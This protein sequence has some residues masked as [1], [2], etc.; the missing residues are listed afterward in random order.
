[1]P[2]LTTG[3]RWASVAVAAVLALSGCN[4]TG[5]A[6]PPLTDAT[7]TTTIE[8]SS[9]TSAPGTAPL[10]AP[11]AGEP[12]PE[13]A[14]PAFGA[15]ALDSGELQWTTCSEDEMY[16]TMIGATAEVVLG[17]EGS[18]TGTFMVA[19]DASDG[20]ELWRRSAFAGG[21]GVVAPGPVGGQ[22]ITVVQTDTELPPFTVA[23]DI[24]SGEERRRLEPGVGMVGQ[25]DEVVVVSAAFGQ[26][27]APPGTEGGLRGIDRATGAELW[28]NDV[29]FSDESGVGVAR[30][31]AA[32]VG[33]TIAVP[34]GTTLTGVDVTTGEVIWTSPQLDHPVG[35]DGVFVGSEHST[36]GGGTGVL[37]AID[38]A[39]GETLW[40]AD[41]QLSYGD[42]LAV[43]DGVVAPISPASGIIAYELT[44]GTVRWTVV[45]DVFAQPQLID[46]TSVI[47]LWE[48]SLVARSTTDGSTTWALTEPMRTPLMNSVTNNGTNVFV[49]ANSLPWSD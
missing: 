35:A 36:T 44:T 7:P 1:M 12:C 2:D 11:P 20:I 9:D 17:M 32:M 49:G 33:D 34:T 46:G 22:G 47:E 31:A 43:G 10:P 30:G 25:T 24:A 42:L 14:Y 18:S 6:D 40:S 21:P 13:G 48:G 28:T 5:S 15:F 27:S 3:S 38:A 39:T 16:R 8:E 29:V 19:L 4:D 23:L 41:G 26:F 37:R 45:P